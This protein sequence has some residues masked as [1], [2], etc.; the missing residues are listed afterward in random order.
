MVALPNP[1]DGATLVTTLQKYVDQTLNRDGVT[2]EITA[3][4]E[5]RQG[6][7]VVSL[8]GPH[9]VVQHYRT[10][11][12][13]SSARHNRRPA[14]QWANHPSYIWNAGSRE[15]RT[16]AVLQDLA[17]ACWHARAP[18]G[19]TAR[20]T[21]DG[22]NA[23]WDKKPQAVCALVEMQTYNRTRDAAEQFVRH[24]QQNCGDSSKGDHGGTAT[25]QRDPRSQDAGQL[26]RRR[27][28]NTLRTA[29]ALARN[30]LERSGVGDARARARHDRRGAPTG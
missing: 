11:F 16:R 1:A 2:A 27:C 30:Q 28:M 14:H 8:K 19:T 15:S 23:E 22:C 24:S 21:L 3:P 20:T 5:Q 9:A 4:I 6:E 17:A 25:C 18:N 7:I 26:L 29:Y 10:K 12:A 13:D